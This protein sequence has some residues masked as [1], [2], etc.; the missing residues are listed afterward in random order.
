[1]IC[2]YLGK[3]ITYLGTLT[4]ASSPKRE[5]FGRLVCLISEAKKEFSGLKDHDLEILYILESYCRHKLYILERTIDFATCSGIIFLAH[6][7]L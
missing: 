7:S 3:P 6:K 1:V 5:R 2:T 4:L